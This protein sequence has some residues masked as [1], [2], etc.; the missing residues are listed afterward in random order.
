LIGQF[1]FKDVCCISNFDTDCR[2]TRIDWDN[3]ERRLEIMRRSDE[4]DSE[5]NDSEVDDNKATND[6]DKDS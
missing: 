2:E 6:E 5:V 4:S 1:E 3:E